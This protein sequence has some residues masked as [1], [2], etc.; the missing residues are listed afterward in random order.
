MLTMATHKPCSVERIIN[1]GGGCP[2]VK[3]H[4]IAQLRVY[5][6]TQFADLPHVA[7]RVA[8]DH[9]YDSAVEILDHYSLPLPAVEG[10]T[11]EIL[12]V[13]PRVVLFILS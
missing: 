10:D 4:G 9:R 3:S 12:S 1:L 5:Q 6:S 13:E 2:G 8:G 11:G 7:L